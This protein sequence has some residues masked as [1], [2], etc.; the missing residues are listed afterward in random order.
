VHF[1][2]WA[3]MLPGLIPEEIVKLLVQRVELLRE[4]G[5]AGFKLR[6]ARG[7]GGVARGGVVRR[8]GRPGERMSGNWS[9][10]CG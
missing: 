2:R 1:L 5:N 7:D 8:G 6:D 3:E 10:V 4:F 9:R